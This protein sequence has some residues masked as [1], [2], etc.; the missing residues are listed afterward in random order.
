MGR[1]QR[2]CRTNT[3]KITYA[4]S[5]HKKMKPSKKGTTSKTKWC[6]LHSTTSHNDAECKAQAVGK[7]SQKSP[8]HQTR[9]KGHNANAAIQEAKQGDNCC[10]GRPRWCH[11]TCQHVT[12][13]TRLCNSSRQREL[14]GFLIRSRPR[15]H[16]ISMYKRPSK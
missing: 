2:E 14:Y 12:S 3:I 8:A 5:S 7:F 11:E 15:A 4:P 10:Q 9:R 13:R 1:F 16:C 6:L